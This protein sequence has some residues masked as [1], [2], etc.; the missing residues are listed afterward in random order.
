MRG[1]VC[2]RD[3]HLGHCTH[4]LRTVSKF[5]CVWGFS[6]V[7]TIRAPVWHESCSI[8]FRFTPE[9]GTNCGDRLVP[10]IGSEAGS[11]KPAPW[12]WRFFVFTVQRAIN[13]HFRPIIPPWALEIFNP[14]VSMRVETIALTLDPYPQTINSGPTE[15]TE[16]EARK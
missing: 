2:L 10:A 6:F 15:Q 3:G 14:I 8:I 5:V 9:L 13:G 4:A 12:V 16:T 11:I 1:A 7:G